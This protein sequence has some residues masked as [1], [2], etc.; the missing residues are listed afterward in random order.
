MLKR[1]AGKCCRFEV[2]RASYKN[3][4]KTA[5]SISGGMAKPQPIRDIEEDQKVDQSV[6]ER[7]AKLVG[8]LQNLEE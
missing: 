1:S 6:V 3:C 5:P 4:Y 8:G 2:R 7:L